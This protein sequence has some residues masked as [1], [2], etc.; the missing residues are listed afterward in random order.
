[1]IVVTSSDAPTDRERGHNSAQ[2]DTSESLPTFEVFKAGR[3]S[4]VEVADE[5]GRYNELS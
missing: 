2:H 4:C 1:M 5:R 3:Y